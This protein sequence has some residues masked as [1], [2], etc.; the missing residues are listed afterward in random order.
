MRSSPERDPLRDESDARGVLAGDGAGPRH[1][2]LRGGRSGLGRWVCRRVILLAKVRGGLCENDRR[3]SP[4][5]RRVDG[6]GSRYD[7]RVSFCVRRL[8]PWQPGIEP[9]VR[10]RRPVA[11]VP[12]SSLN[13]RRRATLVCC[14]P[15]SVTDLV[16][17]LCLATGRLRWRGL[18]NRARTSERMVAVGGSHVGPNCHSGARCWVL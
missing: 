1:E 11:P 12:R 6:S 8:P 5:A 3:R 9:S 18:I 15:R 14:R 10:D 13:C 4:V 7:A 17:D 2:L 16:D